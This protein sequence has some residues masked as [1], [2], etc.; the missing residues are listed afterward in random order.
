MPQREGTTRTVKI[1]NMIENQ[2]YCTLM[3][4][5]TAPPRNRHVT[6]PRRSDETPFNT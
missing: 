1:V 3:K 2:S 5:T 6:P 4:P